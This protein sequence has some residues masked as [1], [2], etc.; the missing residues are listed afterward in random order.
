MGFFEEIRNLSDEDLIKEFDSMAKPSH[1]GPSFYREEIARRESERLNDKMLNYTHELHYFTKWI[2]I[3]AVVSTITAI[4][5]LI[6][7]VVVLF[8]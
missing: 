4:A 2:T 8:R 5:S 6:T 7:S 1:L 3:M